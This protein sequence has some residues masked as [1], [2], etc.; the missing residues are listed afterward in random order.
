[1]MRS[2][3][4]NPDEINDPR[5]KLGGRGEREAEKYLLGKGY[6]ILTRNFRMGRGELDLVCAMDSDLVV[7]EVKSV[8]GH[9]YENGIERLSL[10]QQRKLI[11]TTYMYLA[12]AVPFAPDSVRFDVILVDF[13]GYPVRIHHYE[14]AFWEH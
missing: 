14:A 12:T 3:N 7:V 5:K 9:V 6:Q 4:F 8:R 2:V 11:K 10:R 13:S 1:V